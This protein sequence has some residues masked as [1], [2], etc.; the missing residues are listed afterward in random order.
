MYIFL[1]LFIIFNDLLRL[2]GWL[3]PMTIWSAWKNSSKLQVTWS[4]MSPVYLLLPTLTT[5]YLFQHIWTLL[6]Q[7][8]DH[9]NSTRADPGGVGGAPS[10]PHAWGSIDYLILEFHFA[11][12]Q[13]LAPTPPPPQK[14]P[15]SALVDWADQSSVMYGCISSLQAMLSNALYNVYFH[16]SE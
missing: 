13:C 8:R 7:V 3:V 4:E 11:K 15:G 16:T 12:L 14:F 10:P 6:P 2:V 1:K 9:N 5:E